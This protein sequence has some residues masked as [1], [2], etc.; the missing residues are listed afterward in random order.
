M[1]DSPG[2]AESPAG[3]RNSFRKTPRSTPD[4]SP[5]FARAMPGGG[6]GRSL[7][8][9]MTQ[10]FGSHHNLSPL[11][12]RRYA[13]CSEEFK[14]THL[15]I[16]EQLQQHGR[17][18]INPRSSKWVPYWDGSVTACLLFTALVTP[19]EV[20]LLPDHSFEISGMIYLFIVNRCIDA[21]FFADCILNFFF[22]Y[23]E[24]AAQGGRWV[25]KSHLIR[26][27]YLSTWFTVDI[28]STVPFD[29][30]LQVGAID[31]EAQNASLLRV[32]RIVRFFR[33]IKLMR[34]LRGS[35]IL[36]RWKSY[37]GISYS[38]V[39]TLKFFTA[40]FFMVHL[41]ACAW[42]WMGLNWVPS[43]GITLEWEQS[44][45]DL[46]SFRSSTTT[47]LYVISL[48]VSVVAMFGGVGS[49]P[50][51]NYAE[52][53]LY[54]A[55]MI[56]GSFV[57]A[58][59][60]G[61]LC[62]IIATLNPHKTAFQNTMDELEYFMAERNFDLQHRVRLR[63]FFRQTNDFARIAS[64][65]ALMV[66]MSVQ[67]R[68]DTALKIGIDTLSRVWYFSLQNVEKEFLAVVA[69]N[70]QS[71]LYEAREK[72]PTVDLTVITKGMAARKLR[73]F[74]KGS[75]LG[76]DCIIPDERWSLRDLS[77]ANCL[78]FV[79]TSQISRANLFTI[80]D[81][82]PVAK[83]HIRHAASIQALRAA[84]LQY[85]ALYKEEQGSFGGGATRAADSKSFA[86]RSSTRMA[87]M[88]M[89]HRR[90]SEHFSN[91]LDAIDKAKENAQGENSFN[92]KHLTVQNGH[93]SVGSA[94]ASLASG[95]GHGGNG[96]AIGPLK[97]QLVSIVKAQQVE[98]KRSADILARNEALET[99]CG[100]LNNKLELVV[101][102]LSRSGV[103]APSLDEV[104]NKSFNKS[105]P[106]RL[107]PDSPPLGVASAPGAPRCRTGTTEV[108]KP[109]GQV[110]HRRRKVAI[111]GAV[112]AVQAIRQMK[113]QTKQHSIEPPGRSVFGIVGAMAA[114]DL[115]AGGTLQDRSAP[116]NRSMSQN[117][118][119]SQNRSVAFA[120]EREE[121]M[122]ALH[123]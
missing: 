110:V 100:I 59:V 37:F 121:F 104:A 119:L 29:L 6:L 81:Y 18:V 25:L 109:D 76:T 103:S 65:N 111:R 20:C 69:L 17:W 107:G 60:I 47:R 117:R 90:Q 35:R 28:I 77:T 74:T 45:L 83:Q 12:N 71:A 5:P 21:F 38:T 79:Q 94:T 56:F 93:A 84:F 57:W 16:R 55:M 49:L 44:W 91:I 7:T 22:A 82:F 89:N 31:P 73:I 30:F 122:E 114:N 53:C 64:Y 14:Q 46:Y 11:T 118:S 106:R 23:Q 8:R 51:A 102:L 54:T 34:I 67:L 33:L 108:I 98:A 86:R 112:N 70:L 27:H 39:S 62:G 95:I 15:L 78:T 120:A 42:A 41:M 40:T 52:Y 36:A 123:A 32:F 88:R 4:R 92:K 85:Y 58:W 80:L 113:D 3:Q 101:K 9:Q 1:F 26:K 13:R 48:Y 43:K 24:P 10:S 116:Y 115:Q 19:I 105:F 99:Q 72:L 96:D 87:V 66:K 97:D 61:S 50:P 75:T 63:D 2:K 68:G